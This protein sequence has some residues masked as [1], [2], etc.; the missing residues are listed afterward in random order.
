VKTLYLAVLAG[1]FLFTTQAEMARAEGLLDPLNIFSGSNK[2]AETYPTTQ[3]KQGDS[4]PNTK[5]AAAPSWRMPKLNPFSNPKQGSVSGSVD[6]KFRT[7]WVTKKGFAGRAT[8]ALYK[9]SDRVTGV[10]VAT[11]N[12]TAEVLSP[13]KNIRRV[14]GISKNISGHFAVPPNTLAKDHE[15]KKRGGRSWF[16]PSWFDQDEAPAPI[17]SRGEGWPRPPMMHAE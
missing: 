1:L 3:R 12:A 15:V 4:L 14:Q 8:E 16:L 11:Y 13:A 10:T 17:E 2:S 5:P 9:T 6:R 7:N